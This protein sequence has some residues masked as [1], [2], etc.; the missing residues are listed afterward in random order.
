MQGVKVPNSFSRVLLILFS[1]PVISLSEKKGVFFV[2]GYSS[3]FLV[4]VKLPLMYFLV[5]DSCCKSTNYPGT[6]YFFLFFFWFNNRL[7]VKNLTVAPEVK[8][9]LR[10]RTADLI[11]W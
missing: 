10:A 2:T 11:S 6:G 3:S 1:S 4:S 5:L 8:L 7:C 9:P